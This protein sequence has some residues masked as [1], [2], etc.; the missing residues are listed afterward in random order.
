MFD[1][2]KF[3]TIIRYSN[4]LQ[5]QIVVLHYV[6]HYAIYLILLNVVMA[7]LSTSSKELH[8]Y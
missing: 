4:F 8:K 3:I 2:I 6:L 1:I 5:V 7:Y